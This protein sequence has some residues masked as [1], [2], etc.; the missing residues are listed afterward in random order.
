MWSTAAPVFEKLLETYR[1]IY[2]QEHSKNAYS[3][4]VAL[5]TDTHV[6]DLVISEQSATNSV[7]GVETD[8]SNPILGATE[9]MADS[10]LGEYRHCISHCIELY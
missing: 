8:I 5:I 6:R 7:G 10:E 1:R 4:D 2:A 9:S 3:R